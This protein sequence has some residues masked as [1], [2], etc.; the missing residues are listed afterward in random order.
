MQT[1][2]LLLHLCGEFM[3][4]W[5]AGDNPDI[6]DYLR[7]AGPHGDRL[8]EMVDHALVGTAPPPPSGQDLAMVQALLAGDS[9]LMGLRQGRR[10]GVDSVVADLA[11]ELNLDSR[12]LDRL[13]A[14]YQRLEAGRLSAERIAPQLRGALAKVLGVDRA[15]LIVVAPAP[16]SEE[17]LFARGADGELTLPEVVVKDELPGAPDPYLDGLF[18]E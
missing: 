18:G 7:R 1:E 8:I 13:K 10:L 6:D 2:D 14:L 15:T 11:D 3:A 5:A 4:H 17:A 12:L 9:T 16:P